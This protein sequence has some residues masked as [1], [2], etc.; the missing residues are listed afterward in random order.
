MELGKWGIQKRTLNILHRK[1]IYTDMDFLKMLPRKYMDYTRPKMLQDTKNDET[2]VICGRLVRAEKRYGK[3]NFL[4]LRVEQDDGTFLT[5]MYFSMVFRLPFFQENLGKIF[6]ACGKVSYLFPYGYSMSNP[7]H[8]ILAD[9]Y[10]PFIDPVYTKISGISE[11]NMKRMRNDFLNAVQDPLEEE[12]RQKYHLMGLRQAY[13]TLHFPTERTSMGPALCRVIFDDLFYFSLSMKKDEARATESTTI[14]LRKREIMDLFISMLPFQMT[15]DQMS[16]VDEAYDNSSKGKRN[17]ILIQGDVGC[18]KT[19]VAISLMVLGWENGYQSVLM[20][21]R[22]VLAQQHFREITERVKHLGIKTAF[23]HSGMKS[24]EKKKIYKSIASGDIN[25]VVGTHSC[26]SEGVQYSNL[27]VII[28]DEEHLFGVKQKEMLE[29]KAAE[30]VHSISMSATPIP[31]TLA[32]VLYGESKEISVIRS[33]PKGRLPIITSQMND[34]T[35]CMYFMHQQ[36]MKGHQCYV[37]CPAI[38]ENENIELI[39]IETIEKEYRGYF[40]NKGV[41][42]AVIHGKMKKD[43]ADKIIEDFVKNKYQIL[44]STTVIEVG[45]NVPNTTVMCIEQ[46]ER[47]G[48]ASLHQLR[49]RVGRSSFQ[50]YCILMSAERSERIDTMCATTDGFKIAEADLKQ[51]GSGDLI[52]IKQAGSSQYIDYML[53]YP[54]LYRIANEAAEYCITRG[55]GEKLI[56]LYSEHEL[57]QE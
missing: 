44:I 21:P 30:G 3:K 12:V 7:S 17:N 41:H 43:E 36:I 29:K 31:R 6:C 35:A 54:K 24:A 23:L 56:D 45:V 47:F 52:G 1:K 33:M 28:T 48:L 39:S 37:V 46:A 18:G 51:R 10:I 57:V 25:L 5:I 40:E 34:R 26:I 4:L 20:A 53:R 8:L 19:V 32:A 13:E 27:G 55:Y 22:E 38:E 16:V 49:G 11:E 15:E 50:S 42:V 2:C 9:E 14:R